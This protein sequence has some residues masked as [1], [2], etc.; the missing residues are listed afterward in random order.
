M[1]D[2]N[3]PWKLVW[4]HSSRLPVSTE[5]FQTPRMASQKLLYRCTIVIPLLLT[6]AAA[7][8]SL[9]PE[10]EPLQR[11]ASSDFTCITDRSSDYYGLGVR[12][13]FY[14]QWLTSWVANVS[15]PGE[16]AGALDTNAIFLFALLVSMVRCTITQLLMQLDGLLLM[17]LSGGTI[18]SILSIWGYRTCQYNVDGPSGICHFGGFGTHLRLLLSTAISA[19]GLWYW[20]YG[21]TGGLPTLEGECAEVYTFMFAKVRATGGIRI[22]YIF[23]CISCLVYF[24]IMLLASTIAACARITK[25]FNLTTSRRWKATSR[26]KFSTGFNQK[27]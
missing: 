10:D 11:R 14:F 19:Y 12:L 2:I 9:H 24:G 27:E 20:L 22:F 8:S 7:S 13:G 3:P 21:L 26:L 4:Y 15:V 17:H 23:I 1:I 18:F 16:V 6:L 5:V 25:L